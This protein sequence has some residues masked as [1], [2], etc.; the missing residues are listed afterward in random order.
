[1]SYISLITHNRIAQFAARFEMQ[2]NGTVAYYHPDREH[3]GLPCSLEECQQMIAEFT[4][5]TERTSKIMFYWA[6]FSG[7]VLGI[8]DA[9]GVLVLLRWQQYAVILAPFPFMLYLWRRA[10][11]KPLDLLAGR[12][13]C[14]P[15][16]T[17]DS[18]FW[19]RVAALPASLFVAMLLP[20][21]GL[22]YYGMTDGWGSLGMSSVLVIACNVFMTGLWL[23]ARY[24]KKN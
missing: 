24:G 11:L 7:I 17:I 14:S 22:L 13:H 4:Q 8:L 6:I 19:H 20:C 15:P 10:S 3:G 1:M 23:Y 18:A 16:R 21:V 9:S 12:L 2:A 5:A